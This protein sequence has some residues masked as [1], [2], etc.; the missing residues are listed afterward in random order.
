MKREDERFLDA[1]AS[2]RSILRVTDRTNQIAN[3][4]S[5]SIS[6]NELGL[7]QYHWRVMSYQCQMSNVKCQMSDVRCQMTNVKCQTANVKCKMT[8][9]NSQK[10]N[11][12][13]QISKMLENAKMSILSRM[14]NFSKMLTNSKYI[15][16]LDLGRSCELSVDLV[17][18]Q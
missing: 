5:E 6:E 1:L 7:C 14:S 12:I 15:I 2:L 16:L 9:V 4:T 13:H 3:I 11:A 10:S 8:N 17:R 18:S